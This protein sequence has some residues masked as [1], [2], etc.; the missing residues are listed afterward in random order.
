MTTAV[1]TR[2]DHLEIART[3]ARQPQ[4]WPVE[5]KF[6]SIN[7][8]Y[9]CL[10]DDADAQIW[11]LTWLPGQKTD[12]H[13]HGGSAG[14]FVVVSGAILEETVVTNRYDTEVRSDIVAAGHGRRF[15]GHHV[16]R[17]T[18]TGR[19]PAVSIHVYGPKLETM[20]RYEMAGD[21][22]RHVATDRAGI[23]W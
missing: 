5:P 10:A 23:T 12:L 15:G 6:D 17:M 18:N 7:R 22:L 1:R 11:L 8:W 16:H 2:V 14:A 13:D 3:F 9:A 4:L 21:R 19:S 20:N